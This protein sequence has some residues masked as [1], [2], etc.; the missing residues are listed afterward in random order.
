M[1]N[2]NE[3]NQF[4]MIVIYYNNLIDLIY[5]KEDEANK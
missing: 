3:I 2:V 4:Q 5:C 1:A